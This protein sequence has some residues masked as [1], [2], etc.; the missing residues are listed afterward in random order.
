MTRHRP[1]LTLL[2]VLALAGPASAS[3]VDTSAGPVRI[4]PVLTGLDEPWAIAFLPDGGFLVTERGGRLLLARDG[5]ARPVAGVPKVAARGQG[6]LLDVLVPFDFPD[7]REIWL[8]FA[9]AGQGGAATAAGFGRLSDDGTRL[10]EFQTVF[11]GDPM[12]G[13]RHFG[14]RLVEMPDGSIVLTTGD[15]G[16]GPDG[17]QAQDPARAEGKL[18]RLNRDGT[19]AEARP[20]HRAGVMTLGHRNVQGATLDRQGRLYAVEHGAQGGDELNRIQPGR[21]YGWPVISFG[22][23]YNGER[24]GTGT[25][26]PDMEQPLHYWDPSVAPSGLIV[27]SGRMF[28]EWRGDFL[29]GSLNSD[30]IGR[31]APDRPARTGFAEERIQAPETARVRDL[32]EAADGSVWFL[33]VTEGAVY[34]MARAPG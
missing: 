5:S 9:K 16:T 23:N 29:F 13:S 28:P 12:P 21:N 30:Y 14:S 1:L 20:G 18:I 4:D 24:I 22:V 27:H 6:G 3:V 7:T 2:L 31:L 34:R 17:M 25:T 33:S 15:R 32:A 11:A 8:S 19:P 26:A 10:E